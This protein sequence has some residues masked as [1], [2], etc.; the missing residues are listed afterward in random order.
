MSHPYRTAAP[1]LAP[2]RK[3]ARCWVGFHRFVCLGWTREWTPREVFRC[4]LCG[5]AWAYDRGPEGTE[6]TALGEIP[7]LCE[8][9]ESAMSAALE[10]ARAAG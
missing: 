1:P 6:V 3:P 4:P 9:E 10:R 8:D 7:P 5:G 2:P